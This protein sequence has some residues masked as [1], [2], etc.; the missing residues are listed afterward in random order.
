MDVPSSQFT[1]ALIEEDIVNSISWTTNS[2]IIAT[3]S[4]G[5]VNHDF[6]PILSF[7]DTDSG[8]KLFVIPQEDVILQISFS[9]N[10]RDLGILDYEGTF[11]IWSLPE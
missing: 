6:A 8:N 4:A 3:A 1:N 9:P 7:W 2:E 11:T 5:E 10:G